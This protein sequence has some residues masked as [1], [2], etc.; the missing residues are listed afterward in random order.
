MRVQDVAAGVS[1]ALKS[2]IGDRDTAIGLRWAGDPREQL[3]ALVV[4]AALVKHFDA[5]VHEPDQDKL[6]PFDQESTG[7]NPSRSPIKSMA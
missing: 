5:I 7:S 3:A 2:S 6:L 4:C 1:P